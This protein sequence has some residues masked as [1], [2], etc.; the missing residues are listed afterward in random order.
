[1]DIISKVAK[2]PEFKSIVKNLEMLSAAY[3]EWANYNIRDDP[4]MR[5]GKGSL[6]IPSAL[7]ITKIK[8]IDNIP[9]LTTSLQVFA[10]HFC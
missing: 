4:A 8:D 1:M 9:L 10:K 3:I 5:M 2:L 7:K 6:K